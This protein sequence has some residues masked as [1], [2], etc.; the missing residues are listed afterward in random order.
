MAHQLVTENVAGIARESSVDMDRLVCGME[1]N[2]SNRPDRMLAEL[3]ELCQ[4]SRTQTSQRKAA[5]KAAHNSYR[6][7][8]KGNGMSL[9]LFVVSK[10]N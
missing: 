8:L 9:Q 7:L 4:P 1:R 2:I 10:Q 3:E 5:P 6:R